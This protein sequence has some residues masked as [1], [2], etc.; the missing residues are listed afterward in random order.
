MDAS[1]NILNWFEIPVNDMA[2][3]RKFYEK[4]FEIKMQEMEMQGVQMAFFP[5]DNMSGKLAGA[6][7]KGSFHRP[8]TD[9]VAVYL[10]GNPDL[11]T[12]LARIEGAGGKIKIQ[13]TLINKE[14]G[15]MAFFI[16]TEGNK[17]GLH[18]NN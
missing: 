7:A 16:D 4:I 5:F 14:S 12:V 18:S 11:S 9:G 15:Y 8:C 1:A 10:N 3:A 2:R 6:L 13:K 17:L